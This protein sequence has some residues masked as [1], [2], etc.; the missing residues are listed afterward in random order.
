[1]RPV[2]KL[3]SVS[4]SY[5]TTCSGMQLLCG[6]GVSLLQY[7]LY[8]RH[9]CTFPEDIVVDNCAIC[10]NHIMDLCKHTLY[11]DPNIFVMVTVRH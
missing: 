1:M 5:L 8:C 10:R 2:C 4:L 3:F 6:L 9:M 11:C 7:M